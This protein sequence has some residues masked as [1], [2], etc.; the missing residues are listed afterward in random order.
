[1]ILNSVG[2]GGQNRFADSAA[3]Q[4]LLN[5]WLSGTVHPAIVVDGM[6][7]PQTIG[8]IRNFQRTNRLVVDG[9]ID[10]GGPTLRLLDQYCAALHQRYVADAL[11]ELLNQFHQRSGLAGFTPALRQ[12]IVAAVKVTDQIAAPIGAP[13]GSAPTGAKSLLGFAPQLPVLAAVVVVPA[14]A[15]LLLLLMMLLVIISNPVWQRNAARSVNELIRRLQ[16]A[17]A[18]LSDEIDTA[19]KNVEETLKKFGRCAILCSAELIA[20]RQLTQEALEELRAGVPS[21]PVRR[22]QRM[23]RLANLVTRWNTA[24]S[25]LLDCFNR[26]GCILGG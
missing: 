19:A 25:A 7:G 6:V 12:P 17:M 18:K 2:E 14:V 20:F 8:A 23:L 16:D 5:D 21:D 22:G 13:T 1:M 26:N 3:I 24:F 10:A 9:R 11:S 4:N 15:V